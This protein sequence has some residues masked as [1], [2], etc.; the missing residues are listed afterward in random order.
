MAAPGRAAG[1]GLG[2]A[3]LGG[4]A[5]MA[6]GLAGVWG[7]AT[8]TLGVAVPRLADA[9]GAEGLGG[10]GTRNGGGGPYSRR[11]QRRVASAT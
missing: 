3:R 10:T 2:A 7:A 4:P 11:C 1:R 8:A 6:G 5:A 9:D